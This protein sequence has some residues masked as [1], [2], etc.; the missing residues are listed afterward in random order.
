VVSLAAQITE[1]S[2]PCRG[3]ITIAI[4]ATGGNEATGGDKE[5]GISTL[6]GLNNHSPIQILQTKHGMAA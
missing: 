3:V 6:Q 1:Y 5:H 2:E 4:G